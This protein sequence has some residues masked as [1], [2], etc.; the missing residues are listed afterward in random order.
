MRLKLRLVSILMVL[1]LVLV[2][3]GEDKTSPTS[4]GNDKLTIVTTMFPLYDFAQNIA[5]DN[6][7]VTCLLPAGTEL[8]HWEPSPKDIV[9]MQEADILIYTGSYL[10][11]WMDDVLKGMDDSGVVVVEAGEGISLINS[12]TPHVH[13]DGKVHEEELAHEHENEAT[14]EHEKAGTI[15]PHIWLDPVKAQQMVDNILAVLQKV[16]PDNSQKYQENALAYQ[17]KLQALDEEYKTGL[18]NAPKKEFIVSHDAFGYL[19]NK[20]GLVQ[21]SIRGLS[22]DSEPTPAKIAEIVEL[23]AEHDL[24][25]VFFESLVSPKISET[26]ANEAGADVLL[27]HTIAGLTEEE[28]E[29]NE[30]YISL[31]EDNLNNLKIALGVLEN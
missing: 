3:C 28:V 18:A 17:S 31:M 8:H 11:T 23:M 29:A 14:H 20:Y 9:A 16:D 7:E 13:E 21:I 6:A 10:E 1:A 4:G 30:D 22:A 27:L 24:H 19:A 2:G 26:I 5:L 25:Y 15:D 12:Q